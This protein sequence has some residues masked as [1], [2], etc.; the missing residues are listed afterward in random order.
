MNNFKS[1]VECETVCDA[2]IQMAAE[3]AGEKR[4]SQNFRKDAMIKEKICFLEFE[5]NAVQAK[6]QRGFTLSF[7]LKIWTEIEYLLK[8]EC[9]NIRNV[10]AAKRTR[11]MR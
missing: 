7:Y 6:Q 4:S 9:C 3:A 1:V 5:Q 8:I 2:L 10:H 11:A